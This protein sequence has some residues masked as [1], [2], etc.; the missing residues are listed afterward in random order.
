M[1]ETPPPPR[2]PRPVLAFFLSLLISSAALA[3]LLLSDGQVLELKKAKAEI[4]QLDRQIVERR[5]ENESLRAAIDAANRHD[6]PAEKV[7]REDLH[8]VAP[9][10]LV[11]LFPDGSLSGP[12]PTPAPAVPP[13]T[14]QEP[15]RVAP[16]STGA[17]DAPS[18]LR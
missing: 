10:D 6:F 5:R 14:A 11:L 4:T 18:P 2:N 17:L 12:K 15:R 3:F 9:E 8:L 13:A 7:A 1:R 16:P